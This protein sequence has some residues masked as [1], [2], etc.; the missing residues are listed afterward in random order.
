[1]S[2]YEVSNYVMECQTAVALF[3]NKKL[4]TNIICEDIHAAHI[5]PTRSDNS[6][7][8]VP[9]SSASASSSTQ[10]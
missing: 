4:Q 9:P 6:A 1:M 3:L 2:K 10:S 8:S 7:E 5:L